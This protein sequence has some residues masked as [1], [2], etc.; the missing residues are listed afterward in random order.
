[1]KLLALEARQNSFYYKSR[2]QQIVDF[3]ADCKK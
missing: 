3:G 2:Y 1:M